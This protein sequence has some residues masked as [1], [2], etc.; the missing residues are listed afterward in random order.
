M[1]CLKIALSV[2]LGLIAATPALA[3]QR[4]WAPIA[5]GTVFESGESW[6]SHGKRFRLYGVRACE[7]G[8]SFTNAAGVKHDCGEASLAML[9]SLIRD[10]S[11]VCT[12]VARDE[13]AGVSHVIC[14][15]VRDRGAG[16]GSRIDLGTALISSGFGFAAKDAAGNPIHQEYAVAEEVA[17]RSRTGL[18]GYRFP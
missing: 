16:K 17:K 10:L 18:W 8:R 9:V 12:V 4:Q 15:A 7:R 6:V 5:P 14:L 1:K 3:Q 2:I 13:K 11:P